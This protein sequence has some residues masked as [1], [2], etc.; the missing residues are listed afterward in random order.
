[1]KPLLQYPGAKNRLASWIV[2]YIPEH[3]VYLEPF[4]GSGG[5]FFNKQPCR[6]ET[7]NDL[8]DEVINFF[9]VVRDRGDELAGK[10]E[11][12]PYGRQEYKKSYTV[13]LDDVER[14]RKF[15]VRCWQGFGNSNL[16]QN[17]FKSGQQKISPNPSKTWNKL[18]KTVKKACE[19]LKGVQIE[20]LDA[21][22]IIKRYNTPD[23]FI[24]CDPPYVLDT[25]KSNLYKHEMTD[26]K[27]IELLEV[28]RQHPGKVLIS[29]Y[30]NRLY[31]RSLQGWYKISKQTRAEHGLKRTETLWANFPLEEQISLF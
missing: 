10:L 20:N 13:S 7:I 30:E 17:G 25:R 14:A 8:H 5:V 21:I 11:L 1:M 9:E 6:I 3:E 23:V 29:G 12:T 22:E 24:Y 18:P 28:L 4:F 26:E 27:H 31:E 2:Q 19:R 16:Y 15:A